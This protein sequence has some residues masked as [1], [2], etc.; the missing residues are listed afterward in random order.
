MV[1]DD[2]FRISAV[3][4]FCSE[5]STITGGVFEQWCYLLMP[6]LCPNATWH[7]RGTTIFGAPLGHT[8]DSS[9]DNAE[10][11]GQFSSLQTYFVGSKPIDDLNDAITKHPH[12]RHIWLLAAAESTPLQRTDL[13]NEIA[14]WKS[15]HP[16]VEVYVRDSRQI[17]TFIFERLD[18][19]VLVDDLRSRLP[20]LSRIADENAFGESLPSADGYVREPK[21]KNRS[22]SCSFRV[23]TR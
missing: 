18:S 19:D 13:D 7:H 4:S 1:A 15:K 12:A 8:V 14:Q 21:R 6:H 3:N 23:V 10:Y 9:G 20:S 11:V 22:K 2:Q 17:A 5:I 16:D